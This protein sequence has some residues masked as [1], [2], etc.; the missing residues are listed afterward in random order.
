MLK[1]ISLLRR[2]ADM[3]R[4]AFSAY[5]AGPHAAIAREYPAL[6]KYNQNHVIQRLDPAADDTFE[7]DGMAELWFP[8]AA[9]MR[10]A[11]ESAVRGKLLEDEPR[12]LSGVT[13][14]ML[15]ETG[16][17]DGAGGAKVIILARRRAG[18]TVSAGSAEGLVYAGLET[19]VSTFKRDALWSVPEPPDTVIVARFANLEAAKTAIAGGH[20]PD[21]VFDVWH[22]YHVEEYRIVQPSKRAAR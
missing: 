2:L 14:M 20:W 7:T 10:A 8:D 11:A 17:D 12:F 19:V 16:I 22:A 1:R 6:A 13:G 4:E 3:P 15:G 5:W 9:R 21:A 18:A